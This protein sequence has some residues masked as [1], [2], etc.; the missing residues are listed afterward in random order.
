M[1]AAWL[2]LLGAFTQECRAS[3]VDDTECE[4]GESLVY[5]CPSPYFTPVGSTCFY[6][7]SDTVPWTEAS[8]ACNALGASLATVRDAEE[9]EGLTDLMYPDVNCYIG[10]NDISTVG[11]FVWA[12]DDSTLGDYTNWYGR[13]PSL[14]STVQ[15]CV[16]KKA[17]KKGKWN[18]VG[19][20]KRLGANYACSMPATP[21]CGNPFCVNFCS[22]SNFTQVGSGSACFYVSTESLNWRDSSN[23]CLDMGATLA[24]VY[25]KAE[26]DALTTLMGDTNC[27]I[28][29][30]DIN[31]DQDFIWEADFTP[32]GV[33]SNWYG[34]N[35]NANTV[36]NCV[37]KKAARAGKWDNVGC[38]KT[39][40]H[41]ACR[42]EA[43][44]N[45]W[46]P[47]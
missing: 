40:I 23:A 5:S 28:G 45:C 21:S 38:K 15:N 19:C 9:D 1:I 34:T 8:A 6:V 46:E 39:D 30:N 14:T 32:L 43:E 11:S 3:P 13:N 36:Q 20:N 31:I 37:I 44:E 29:L 47:N 26:D 2:L 35:P 24:T 7:S 25:T 22:N 18:D 12:E 4:P 42:M 41:Y 17:T 10:L 16:V 33:Y 27:Y